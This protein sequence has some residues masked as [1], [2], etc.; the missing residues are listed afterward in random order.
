[1]PIP[2]PKSNIA[3]P[4]ARRRVP[5]FP[6]VPDVRD[7]SN[8]SGV[9][10]VSDVSAVHGVS[11]NAR[12]PKKKQNTKKCGMPRSKC[13]VGGPRVS[14]GLSPNAIFGILVS[15]DSKLDPVSRASSV[16]GASLLSSVST[17]SDA[18][19]PCKK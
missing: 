9:R 13:R 14:K 12:C 4:Q 3:N 10:D 8:V 11:A 7:V 16:S 19:T 1:M 5:S 2:N 17:V 15:R 18:Y 6:C